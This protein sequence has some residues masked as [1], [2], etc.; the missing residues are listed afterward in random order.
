MGGGSQWWGDEGNNSGNRI[1][2][3]ISVDFESV[4]TIRR[5]KIRISLSMLPTEGGCGIVSA[6]GAAPKIERG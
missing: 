1:G 3:N 4:A 2:A 6:G 5:Q